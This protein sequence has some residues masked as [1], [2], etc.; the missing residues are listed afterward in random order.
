MT[1]GD[2]RIAYCPFCMKE[3]EMN[4]VEE[5]ETTS[6]KNEEVVFDSLYLHCEECDEYFE[7]EELIKLNDLR[8]KDAYRE[9]TGLLKSS[10]ITAIRKLYDISQNDLSL[11]LHWGGKTVTRYE[12]HQVQEKAHDMILKKISE[13]PGWYTEILLDS[14]NDIPEKRFKKYMARALELYKKSDDYYLRMY[15]KS[16]CSAYM[17]KPEWFGRSELSLSKIVDVINYFASSEDVRSLYKVKLMKLMWY[18]DFLSYKLRDKSITGLPYVSLPMGAVPE[19][20]DSIIKLN[21]VPCELKDVNGNEAYYFHSNTKYFPSLNE[22]DKQILDTI[23]EE[24]GKMDREHLVERMHQERAFTD[25]KPNSVISYEY[26][27]YLTIG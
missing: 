16:K 24:F 25:T 21:G 27:K 23:I 20:H 13:D 11:L 8:M 22:E 18:A 26:A 17:E 10:D 14:R 7:D 5:K 19:A 12:S 2:R 4:I 6:Y 3:H 15:I 1:S 9:K